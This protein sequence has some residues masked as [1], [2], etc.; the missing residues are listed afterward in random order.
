[1]TNKEKRA[2]KANEKANSDFS[3]IPNEAASVLA[4]VLEETPPVHESH[5][6]AQAALEPGLEQSLGPAPAT[7]ASA[8]VRGIGTFATNLM[9]TT[10]LANKEILVKVLAEFAGAKTTYECIAW[11]RSKIRREAA[12]R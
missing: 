7:P 12:G 5:H 2:K 10:E 8:R 1:M 6:E 4:T 3:S 9:K 11:Y